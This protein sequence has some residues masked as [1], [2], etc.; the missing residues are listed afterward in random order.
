[1]F[2]K[3]L[4]DLW[5]KSSRALKLDFARSTHKLLVKYSF[6]YVDTKSFTPAAT[7]LI[8]FRPLITPEFKIK[9]LKYFLMRIYKTKYL[10]PDSTGRVINSMTTFMDDPW[11]VLDSQKRVFLAR[12]FFVLLCLFQFFMFSHHH[13]QIT[14]QTCKQTI[15]Y[16]W[17][18]ATSISELKVQIS[19]E[20]LWTKQ[21]SVT[22]DIVL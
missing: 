8:C 17:R 7:Y 20:H 10:K 5:S 3:I 2:C 1:M 15:G 12:S 22:Q 18:V 9:H 13:L 6:G 16:P 11:V 14:L 4:L 21:L 19:W